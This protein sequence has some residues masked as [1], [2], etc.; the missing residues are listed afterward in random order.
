M[1]LS[2]SHP[3]FLW[4]LLSI[5]LL[6]ISH[7]AFLKYVK[8]RAMRFAN[9]QA[10]KRVSEQKILTKNHVIL[11][12]RAFILCALIF[13]ISGTSVW[14][15]GL[16]NENDFII[17]IDASSSMS[18]QDFQP[19]R[20]EA[21]KQ[22]TNGF[23]DNLKSDSAVGLVSFAGA[24]F[25]ENLPTKSK[26]ELK[27]SLKILDIAHEGGT[28]IADAI[29]TS[30]NLLLSSKK[31]KTIVLL[32]DG[33]NTAGYFT[34]D[35]ISESIKYA[36]Q[37]NIMIYTIGIGTNSAPIG[38]LPEY[39][40]ISSVY[41]EEN[42]MRIANNTGGQYYNAQSNAQIQQAYTNILSDTKESY[43]GIDLS[44]GLLIIALALIFLEWGL[45]STRFRAIP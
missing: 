36:K 43:L 31:G 15:K 16:S 29:I 26:T 21:A 23:L 7:F 3:G 13:A 11:I 18:A 22:Y 41:D 4:Y 45:I 10:L 6:I 40:N 42:L 19:S 44:V 5:P 35:P 39:Y 8:R 34:K 32:T 28:N 2:F 14:Y 27:D 38:Y 9:F 30:T 25:I 12:I 37:N 24:A 20:F 33:S 1:Y 17:A